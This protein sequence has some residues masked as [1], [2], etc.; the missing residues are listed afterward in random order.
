[1]KWIVEKVVIA[2]GSMF[3]ML[4]VRA[5]TG[6][7]LTQSVVTA[8]TLTTYDI[9][10][11]RRCQVGDVATLSISSAVSNSLIAGDARFTKDS[12]GYNTSFTITS[13][14]IDRIYDYRL[15]IS[16]NDGATLAAAW[17]LAGE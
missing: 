5:M 10:D 6:T 12:I 14:P 4:R 13:P 1:M 3:V 15:N 16:T 17:K 7:Y 2:D 8:M 11:G 9:T